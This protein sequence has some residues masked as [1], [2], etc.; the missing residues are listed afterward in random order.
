MVM[1]QILQRAHDAI[2]SSVWEA[3]QDIAHLETTWSEADLAKRV[4]KYMYKSVSNPELLSVPWDEMCQQLVKGMFH[5]YSAACGQ[6]EWFF[7]IDL[8]PALSA[9]AMVLL[10]AV[11]WRVPPHEVFE[12]INREY[13]LSLDRITLDRAMKEMVESLFGDDEKACTKVF[14]AIS[15]AYDPALQTALADPTPME[16]ISR[17][18]VF[19][20]AWIDDTACRAWGGLGDNAESMLTEE[21]L[22]DMFDHLLQPFGDEHPFSAIP[23]MLTENIGAP[24]CGWDFIPEVVQGLFPSWNNPEDVSRATKRRKKKGGDDPSYDALMAA[25]DP[26]ADPVEEAPSPKKPA[27]KKANPRKAQKEIMSSGMGHPDCTSGPDCAG[28]P[29]DGMMR[30]VLEDG[31]GDVYCETCWNSFTQRNPELEGVPVED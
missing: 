1:D 4:V 29:E 16:D 13:N 15:R 14:R 7:Q 19:T 30:H 20:K 17:V 6:A 10:P 5:S 23:R 9:A 24:P 21:T 25:A 22:V 11:G 28:T 26:E 12:T 18:E 27:Y 3:V 31:P 8:A 2:S